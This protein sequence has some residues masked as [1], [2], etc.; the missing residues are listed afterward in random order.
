M[1]RDI[2]WLQSL[3]DQDMAAMREWWVDSF[4]KDK[5]LV[6]ERIQETHNDPV[7]ELITRFAQ[8][9]FT[10]MELQSKGASPC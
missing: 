4:D 2:V 5:V 1:N 3:Q 8:V 7:D 10:Q 6:W 9:A